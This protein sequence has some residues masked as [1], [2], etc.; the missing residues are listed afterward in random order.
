MFGALSLKP[1]HLG[2]RG[3]AFVTLESGG[4]LSNSTPPLTNFQSP[5][6]AELMEG[7]LERVAYSSHH[8]RGRAYVKEMTGLKLTAGALSGLDGFSHFASHDSMGPYPCLTELLSILRIT[9]PK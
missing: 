6:G 1:S 3:F 4:T 9:G 2:L 5:A 7:S 8:Q